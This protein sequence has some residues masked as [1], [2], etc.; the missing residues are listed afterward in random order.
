M[1]LFLQ[2]TDADE[3]TFAVPVVYSGKEELLND[4]MYCAHEALENG[5]EQ[6]EF[7]GA[8]FDVYD[9]FYKPDTNTDWQDDPP[10]ILTVDEYFQNAIA[11]MGDDDDIS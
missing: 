7:F 3:M 2:Y 4:F 1:K 9:F 6:F 10:E 8:S 11:F 5:L